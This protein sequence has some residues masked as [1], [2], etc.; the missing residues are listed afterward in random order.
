MEPLL[1]GDSTITDFAGFARFTQLRL[2]RG[3]PAAYEFYASVPQLG[4][5]ADHSYAV[6]SVP[7][8]SKV[9]SLRVITSAPGA[10]TSVPAASGGVAD[11]NRVFQ[12]GE[13]LPTMLVHVSRPWMQLPTV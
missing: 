4:L 3:L 12:F 11:P 8:T 6:G 1:A 5:N 9:A 7:L 2:L 13:A 10:G